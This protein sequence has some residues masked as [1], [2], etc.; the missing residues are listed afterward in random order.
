MITIHALILCFLF[1]WQLC[2]SKYQLHIAPTMRG[3]NIICCRKLNKNRTTRSGTSKYKGFT[4]SSLLRRFV[5]PKVR[6]SE[7]EGLLFLRFLIVVVYWSIHS[8]LTLRARVRISPSPCTF[9][10]QQG[11][12]ST[13]LLSTQVYKW[14]PVRMWQ[15][16]VFEFASAIITGCYTRQ[17][18]LPGEP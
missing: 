18:M 9:V 17:G 2:L 16:I 7:S 12:L 1:W 6:Y 13:L 11:N 15:M 14:A 8:T 4:Y 10:I 3:L 5:I